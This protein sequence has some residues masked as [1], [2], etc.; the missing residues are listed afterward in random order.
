LEGRFSFV[1]DFKREYVAEGLCSGSADRRLFDEMRD[2][3]WRMK[4]VFEGIYVVNGWHDPESRSGV[5]ST[6]YYTLNIRQEIV[7][8][9]KKMEVKTF[10]DAPC[11]DFNWMRAVEFPSELKY[12]GGDISPSAI[13][14]NQEKFTS[15]KVSFVEFDITQD[16][17]PS[18]DVWFCRDCLF[19]LS[20]KH[21]FKALSMFAASDIPYLFTTTHINDVGFKNFDIESGGFR[22]LDLYSP[23]FDLTRSI[24]FWAADAVYPHPR[25][26][27]CVWTREQ[28]REALPGMAQKI[29]L[30]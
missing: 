21:I 19:H 22:P 15:D 30:S 29:L 26:E 14:D 2:G 27:M 24:A 9:V 20:Y 18:A 11:G 1:R 8:F 10:F 6:L 7:A 13:K 23:P 3:G 4:D 16:V 12:I 25:R 17:F 5:G 28:V